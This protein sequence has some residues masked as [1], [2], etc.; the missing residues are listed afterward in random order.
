MECSGTQITPLKAIA[1]G[2]TAGAVGA[3]AMDLIWSWRY[4]RSGGKSHLFW[5]SLYSIAAGS[6]RCPRVL[7]GLW[8]ATGVWTTSYMVLPPAKLYKPFWEYDIRT[9]LKD[10][11]AHLAYGFGTA[12]SFALIARQAE[13]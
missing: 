7:F 12:C 9:L 4:K 11:T 3:A 1:C 5:G 2:L 6:L 13:R 10:F 8:L